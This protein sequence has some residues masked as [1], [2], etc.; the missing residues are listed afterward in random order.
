MG[1]ERKTKD[2]INRQHMADVAELG[3]GGREAREL[4]QCRVEDRMP[5]WTL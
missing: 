3:A 4:E 1:P 2:R 5:A